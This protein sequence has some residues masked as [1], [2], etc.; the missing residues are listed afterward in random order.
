MRSSLKITTLIA[1][2]FLL[3]LAV[4]LFA[5]EVG[6]NDFQIS[7][8]QQ[9]A[10]NEGDGFT[11]R[12]AYN[13]DL[14]EYLVV[15][16]GDYVVNAVNS[17]PPRPLGL[18]NDDGSPE[19]WDDFN[20]GE[21]EN[22]YGYEIYGVRLDAETGAVVGAQF[23]ISFMTLP[24]GNA[25][26][27]EVVYNPD[28]TEYFVVWSG[29][30]TLDDKFEIYG[31]RIDATDGTLLGTQFQISYSGGVADAAYDAMMP[32]VA[33]N[34]THAEYLVTWTADD[35]TA[36]IV[37]N[38]YEIFGQRLDAATDAFVGAAFRIS[39]MGPDGTGGFYYF[40]LNSDISYNP[41][42]D[43]YLVVWQGDDTDGSQGTNSEI[44]GQRIYG[45]AANGNEVGNN[46]FAISD[47][48]D[49]LVNEFAL[50][51]GNP[52]VV[53]NSTEQEYFVVWY[54]DEDDEPLDDNALEIFGQ[55]I[56]GN[57]AD[58]D[59]IGDNDFRISDMAT[60]ADGA[61]PWNYDAAFPDVVYNPQCNQ[62]LVTWSGEDDQNG[63]INGE[64]EIFGQLLD[65]TGT[66]IGTNDFQLSDMGG[67]NG[68][69]PG[70]D[71]G[72]P[73]VGF[74][75][76]NG[77]YLITWHG[78]DETLGDNF[79]EIFGQLYEP[80]LISQTA[81]TDP[82]ETGPTNGVLTLTLNEA[83][84]VGGLTVTFSFS[85]TATGPGAAAGDDYN[86]TAD[87]N[88]SNLDLIGGTFDID[89]GSL[90][91]TLLITP[92]DDD[93]DDDAE[94]IQL[95]IT[96]AGDYCVTTPDPLTIQDNDT[97]GITVTQTA[98]TTEVDETGPTADT[99]DVVLTS[100]PL[101]PVTVDL[102]LVGTQVTLSTA[103]LV[104][105]DTDWNVAQTVT[106]TAV[107]DPDAEATPHTETISF[108]VT[109][110]DPLYDGFPLTDID[111]D[112]TDND[113]VGVTVTES[114]GTT[115][116][117]EEGPTSDTFEVVL[118]T[119]PTNDVTIDLAVP[120]G[121][122]SLSDNSLTFG[123]GDWETP[124][125]VT[126]TAIDDSYVEAN[127]HTSEVTFTLS[128]TDTDYDGL[129]VANLSA[130]VADNDVARVEIDL[131]NG[132]V[133]VSEGG[134][135]DSYSIV[136]TSSPTATVTITID[137]DDQSRV[138]TGAVGDPV[139]IQF[140]DTNWNNPR[141]ITVYADNDAIAE[142]AHTSNLTHTSSSSDTDYG[143]GVEFRIDGAVGSIVSVNITDNDQAGVQI[144]RGGTSTDVE[145]GGLGDNYLVQLTS[146][147]TETVTISVDP[148]NQLNLGAGTGAAITLTFDN[149]DWNI[150][151]TVTVNAVDDN[152]AEG[153]HIGNINH[154]ASSLDANYN[155]LGVPFTV[156]GNATSTIQANITDNDVAGIT[157]SQSG[158]STNVTEGGTTDTYTVVLDTRPTAIVTVTINPDGQLDLGAGA[159]NPLNLTFNQTDWSTPNTITVTAFDDN[160]AE[161]SHSGLV[162]HSS[163]SS[164][165]NYGPGVPIRIDGGLT[166]T[167]TANISDNDVAS[168]AITQSGGSTNVT[169]G[170][171][172]DSYDVVLTSRPTQPVT[173]T[174][175]PDNQS[176]VG[177]GADNTIQLN[178]AVNSWDMP[179]NVT[180][181]AFDDAV[182]EGA[183]TSSIVHSASSSDANYDGGGVLFTVDGVSTSTV[184]ANI[185][186][187]DDVGVTITQTS[188]NTTVTEGSTQDVYNIVLNTQ[189]AANVTVT[190]TP[191]DS[192]IGVGNGAGNPI[193][194]TF[195]P[196]GP[197][198]WN[199]PQS[200]IVTATD[201]ALVQGNHA[202][203]IAHTVSSTDGNYNGGGVPIT[204]D[205]VSTNIVDVTIIDNDEA[206]VAITQSGGSTDVSEDG[207][208]DT[209]DVVLNS[210]PTSAVTITITP[211]NQVDLGNGA[212]VALALQFDPPAGAD[213][214]N[215]PQTVTVEAVNDLVDEGLQTST[216]THSATSLDPDYADPALVFFVDGSITNTVT[217]S[218]TDNDNA[219]V[220]I[221]QTASSTDVVEGGAQDT[222]E[223]VLTSEPIAQ[224]QVTII[225]DAEVDLGNGA[226]GAEILNFY[227]GAPAAWNVPQTV[228]VQATDDQETEG[229]HTGTIVHTTGSTDPNYNLFVTQ[230]T[231]DGVSG[232]SITAN[233]TDNDQARVAINQLNGSVDVA[234]GGYTDAYTIV[235]TSE[236]T[237]PVT[238][239]ISPDA[240]TNL[241]AGVGNVI[242][243]TFNPT[244]PNPWYTA[245]TVVVTA[246]DDAIAE[247]SHAG[248]ISHS[249]SS[250]D[251]NYVGSALV[252]VDGAT[253]PDVTV[254][255]EDN[256][257][258]GVIITRS[259]GATDVAESGATDT[260]Q[261]R[262][263]SQP[264]DN[265]TITLDPDD[266]LDLGAGAGATETVQFTPATWNNPA[267][268][269]VTAV[270]D[271]IAETDPHAGTVTHSAASN[272]PNYDGVSVAFTID[273]FST[274]MLAA[275]I[276][277]NDVASISIVQT[278]GTTT[279]E[280][281]GPGDTYTVV[282]TSE[283]LATVTVTLDQD[284]QLALDGNSADSAI[285][286]VFDETN[287]FTPRTV[288]VDA[289]DDEVAEGN[290]HSGTIS[291]AVASADA[292]Y[293]DPNA[294]FLID[295]SADSD[296][297]VSI[298]DDDEPGVIVTPTGAGTTCI[299]GGSGD[300]Y[301][302]RLSS[303]PTQTVTVT[304]TPDDQLDVGSGASTAIHLTFDAG[305][306]NIWKTVS[307]N[308]YDD[309]VDE[310]SPH[311]GLIDHAVS[312]TDPFY[313][314]N[315][316]IVIDGVQ[317]TDLSVAIT[318][319]DQASIA[320]TQ[321]SGS[322]DLTEGGA[323]DTYEVVL[324]SQPTD[325]VTITVMTD[326]QSTVST[327][328]RNAI[329]LVFDANNWDQP[330]T[331]TLTAV[332]DAIAEGTHT[333]TVT[334]A[335]SSG[336][337]N[338]DAAGAIFT[339]DG[340]GTHILTASITDNDLASVEITRSDGS[341]DLSE[342]GTTDTYA[343]VLS[344]EPTANVTISFT[345]DAQLNA[346]SA[347]T[348]SD[349]DWDT[350]QSV[351]VSA[352]DDDVAEGVHTGT[353][354][355][356]ATSAD[357]NYNGTGVAFAVDGASTNDV[358][359][360]IA[361]NDTASVLLT[362]TAETTA[363]TE[364]GE[365]DTLQVVLSSEP[366]Q[367]V[368]ISLVTDAQLNA[369]TDLTF[370]ATDWNVVRNVE[371]S[372]AEDDLNE[373]D[374]TG[375]I[376][377]QATSADANYDA[378]ATVLVD[379]VATDL[380][381]VDIEDNDDAYLTLPLTLGGAEG[382]GWNLVSWNADTDPDSTHLVFSEVL[383]NI[384]VIFGYDQGASSYLPDLPNLSSLQ[385]V[386]HL[387]GY[388]V[389]VTQSDTVHVQGHYVDPQTP[390]ELVAGWNL[391][392]Y[393]HQTPDSLT[394]ALASIMDDVQVVLGYDH[395]ALSFYPDLPFSNLYIM[396]PG[397]GYWIR[398][399]APATLTYPATTLPITAAAVERSLVARTATKRG[400]P[401]VTPTNQWLDVYGLSAILDGE[402]L[403]VG[404]I[405]RAVDSDGT[406]CGAVE[407]TR[408]G[409]FG[410]LSV[411]ADDPRT[412]RDEG[413]QVGDTFQLHLTHPTLG[414]AVTVEEPL[415]WTQFGD[416]HR[417]DFEATTLSLPMAFSLSQ[418]YPNPFNPSTTIA[419]AVPRRTPVSLSV[420][421]AAGQL[422]RTV[423]DAET[424]DP[425]RYE[426]RWDGR[427]GRGHDVN[428]GV[429]FYRLH[430]EG[431][432]QTRRM[433]LLR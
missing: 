269:T 142:G 421:N 288:T 180:V 167:L 383:D 58:G 241:G 14:D 155:G 68:A 361:D 225:P 177:N 251:G 6:T 328:V 392:S 18:F 271:D 318:D 320:I 39:D 420:Y 265:V 214:W 194:L 80:P 191:A 245:Q 45:D 129:P 91:A 425:G 385:E 144:T 185:T 189:P 157:I 395:G 213:P 333:S 124:Q 354:S 125:T 388:W 240:Q 92:V 172:T 98:G 197:N 338:Y 250:S 370:T 43:E 132:S 429:Y 196:V 418:N 400:L 101:N 116:V 247:G 262:L 82:D 226:G 270:D 165:A 26:Q 90:T 339:V 218:I 266:Q 315:S 408:A 417:A 201:D 227:P 348:F 147:P 74:S 86:V 29:D 399:S 306:W 366:T 69:N 308:A 221:T 38:D 371:V 209:Y 111:V 394:H 346:I 426:V 150:Q 235:L 301:D 178:F 76:V 326:A 342:D 372:A 85:G 117:D 327:V 20:F 179:Q 259:D 140:D 304:I 123:Y 113:V 205:G 367:P 261:V 182:N 268:I 40:G 199:S 52:V 222:Y 272:D 375:L 432:D 415:R 314:V 183:H 223:I 374:H 373:G 151:Q 200:I 170:G 203:S 34:P 230:M 350:P 202:S 283:P 401:D 341:T 278:G 285:Q 317:N 61:S 406:I 368:T 210:I 233:I 27:P 65:A 59:A 377:V 78:D 217:V 330:Q 17:N 53:Y 168:V 275:V 402:P 115:A 161:G 236:P 173:I 276:A 119:R 232:N 340:N 411:Y 54:G 109:S 284:G 195:D 42:F 33:Y 70:Y 121:E 46:D 47:M 353:I 146:E 28:R 48:G 329:N 15:W 136:L 263:R 126:I 5:A 238:V 7:D 72:Q 131:L 279:V 359:A 188:G 154:S 378:N 12:V 141:V 316:I 2:C 106:V 37:D 380:I 248:T 287:W 246:V 335:A 50:E 21:F 295:G 174:I 264:L 281:N 51:A 323:T 153:N 198:P 56:P 95:D 175:D 396:R 184:T 108:T 280:E 211:D 73:S 133:D 134:T 389:K 376:T 41:D 192:E 431:F 4:G 100:E 139:A 312:S 286:L 364:D 352:V 207:T 11:P 206:S 63:L 159:G 336:D 239:N 379:G 158:L 412:E 84:P 360:S 24:D 362:Q 127:P 337:A 89:A 88:I 30:Q 293:N 135:T 105:D 160:I 163:A 332:D 273:G 169:E 83:A 393:L 334:H 299:E 310:A 416:V 75:T 325:P 260:Y 358:V 128:S 384:T 96:D 162:V 3:F 87:T 143:P 427:N 97:A 355:H 319:N 77:T 398:L 1:T 292:N 237:Q 331:A 181:T 433:V 220:A 386:D 381:L 274:S 347:I 31:R 186:D 369:L 32:A 414:F 387:H 267:T 71:A 64:F 49:G 114:G 224:V 282:L 424:Y 419:F 138:N 118:D 204:V 300:S 252:L 67:A 152:V 122:T 258:A 25:R 110:A 166:A 8:M 290:P 120:D 324:T 405:V 79:F 243:R 229:A 382:S 397:K 428:S 137:P 249:A 62:Y 103:Q 409:E 351:T 254:N 104:F 149:T 107:D 321:S 242:T 215:V 187:N 190:V 130:D 81:T 307:V 407:V 365:T 9:S 322:T 363:V 176:D 410:I 256:D 391:I 234:E 99:F 112:I 231:V 297:T 343:V 57:L 102:S 60:D 36:P 291:H 44:Y 10:P 171:S 35:D 296:L 309:A 22:E 430:A 390:I 313:N 145:E 423:V 357:A 302:V 93:I 13:P 193:N 305:D 404:T 413:P 257:T 219:S 216:L 345:V 228:T 277:E 422:V 356:A 403:P 164:D 255:V 303:E 349:S 289:D 148:D 253:T 16:Q 311:A 19:V 244:T 23:Q 344:S 208:T 66:E 94:T 55:R 294:D 298:V 156:N 212:G